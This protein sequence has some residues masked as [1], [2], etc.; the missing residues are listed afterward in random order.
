MNR[1]GFTLVELALV[2][3]IP[4]I[5]VAVCIWTDRN[6]DYLMTWIAGAPRNCPWW[7]STIATIIGNG[8]ILLFNVVME[9]IRLV[10]GA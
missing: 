3:I 6:L 4:V 5:I 2:L 1:K 7:L 8:I 9:I 10:R